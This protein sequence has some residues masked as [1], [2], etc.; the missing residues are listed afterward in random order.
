MFTKFITPETF[1][2]L[3]LVLVTSV[4]AKASMQSCMDVHGSVYSA[5]S[6]YTQEGKLRDVT[7][8]YM[9]TDKETQRL[10]MILNNLSAQA[11]ENIARAGTPLPSSSSTVLNNDQAQNQSSN[12]TSGSSSNSNANSRSNSNAVNNN[13]NTNSNTNRNN[14]TNANFTGVFN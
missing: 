13:S 12:S 1:G 9:Y 4:D 6:C 11:L 3:M 5:E 8:E 2:I 7:P 10:Q 14:N